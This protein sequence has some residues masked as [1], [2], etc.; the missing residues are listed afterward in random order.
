MYLNTGKLIKLSAVL[1]CTVLLSACGSAYDSLANNNKV[2]AADYRPTID[3][4]ASRKSE[5]QYTNDL[6][7]CRQLAMNKQAT[8]AQLAP[9][10]TASA[11]SVG[12]LAGAAIGAM[13]EDGEYVDGESD[14]DRAGQGALY[15]ALSSLFGAGS[16]STEVSKAGRDAMDAC[17]KN[18]GYIIY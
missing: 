13:T 10:D 8:A 17:L 9:E 16:R 5:A 15:G 1:G 6:G 14:L 12:A 11:G 3:L 18:R 4:V 2:G 7:V